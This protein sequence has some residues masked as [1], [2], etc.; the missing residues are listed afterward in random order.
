MPLTCKKCGAPLS[1][2]PEKIAGEIV[3]RCRAC[4]SL[5][6]IALAFYVL[7]LL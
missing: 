2:E 4:D 6:V 3:V 5:N 1:A 7:G